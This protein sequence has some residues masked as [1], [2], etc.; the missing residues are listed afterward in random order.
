M[1]PV[2]I[3]SI[4]FNELLG[5]RHA[6]PPFLLELAKSSQLTN[7]LGTVH[8]SVQLALAEATSGQILISYFGETVDQVFAVVRRLEAKFKSPLHGRILSRSSVAHEA[9]AAFAESLALKGRS[10]VSIPVEI[11]DESESLGLVATV[12]WFAQQPKAN[13]R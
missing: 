5:I 9:L 13:S 1:Q 2:R 12:E 11:L 3:E 8:A 10:S 4:P 6:A 7:H